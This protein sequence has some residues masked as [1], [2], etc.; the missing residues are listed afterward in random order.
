MMEQNQDNVITRFFKPQVSK[1]KVETD[2]ASLKEKKK[3]AAIADENQ[4]IENIMKLEVLELKL[5]VRLL[6]LV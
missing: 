2:V 3:S 6:Q 1:Q 4:T 5:G